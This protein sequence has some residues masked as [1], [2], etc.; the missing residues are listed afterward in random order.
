MEH[1]SRPMMAVL[2]ERGLFWWDTGKLDDNVIAPDPFVAGLLT[3]A[4]DGRSTLE[5]DGYLPNEHGPFS[6][7]S[8]Q[9]LPE[10]KRIHGVL[11]ESNKQV[12]LLSLTRDGGRAATA[13]IS[14]EKFSAEYCLVS[15]RSPLRDRK[16]AFRRLEISLE[17]LEEWLRLNALKA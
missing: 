9:L 1:P 6:A 13:A 14:Y 5:L 7:F 4:D 8:Q 15:E 17:G 10:T 3:I 2:E 12:L 16:L 11:K